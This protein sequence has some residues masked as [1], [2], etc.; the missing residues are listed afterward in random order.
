M[1]EKFKTFPFT[2]A[3]LPNREYHVVN[4][5]YVDT[6][7]GSLST[8]IDAIPVNTTT[9]AV[10]TLTTALSA[11]FFIL[12]NASAGGFSI[13]LASAAVH[14]SKEF[15]IKKIDQSS[16]VVTIN[17]SGTETIDGALFEYLIAQNEGIH[18]VSDGTEWHNI[19]PLVSMFNTASS[20]TM[21]VGTVTTAFSVGDVNVFADGLVA[22]VVEAAGVPGFNIIVDFTNVYHFNEVL[23]RGRYDGT[24]SHI[25]TM[26]IYNYNTTNWDSLSLVP[27]TSDAYVESI[28][29]IPDETNYISS[30]N[31]RVRIYH[32]T[33]GNASH[34]YYLDYIALVYRGH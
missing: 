2:P 9:R 4:K 29:Y 33:T 1:T 14:E 15:Y 3:D 5:L 12:A 23:L 22:E 27:H 26:Q 20:I 11:D 10:N 18:I 28:A 8:R 19:T 21:S 6:V 34:E 31:A 13:A 24:A 16:N 32:N 30:N 7:D 25:V 17:P